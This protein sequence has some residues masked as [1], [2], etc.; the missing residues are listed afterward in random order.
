M[1][2]FSMSDNDLQLLKAIRPF[3]SGKS[4]KLLDVLITTMNVFRPPQTD[5]KINFDALNTLMVMIE[6][7]VESKKN[8]E[9]IEVNEYSTFRRKSL[10]KWKTC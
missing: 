2:S 3:M 6:E 5:Q 8:A 9:V 10:K 1:K 7:S 4:Q